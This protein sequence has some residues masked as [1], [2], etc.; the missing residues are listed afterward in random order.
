MPEQQAP[1]SVQ[2]WP[3]FR[4]DIMTVEQVLVLGSQVPL[5]QSV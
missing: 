4:Q 2:A 5:Q 3:K 1:L